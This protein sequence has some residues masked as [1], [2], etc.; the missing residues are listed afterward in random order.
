M[1]A[2]SG[3]ATIIDCDQL[4]D[5]WYFYRIG[6]ITAS[7][8]S[9]LMSKGKTRDSIIYEKASEIVTS[10]KCEYNFSGNADTRRGLESEPKAIAL[11]EDKYNCKVDKIGFAM[12]D[13]FVGCSPDG[14][15]N[16]KKLIEIKS[17]RQK[18]FLRGVVDGI[19]GIKKE[20]MVQIQFNLYVLGLNECDFI[21]YCDSFKEPIHVIN[22][23][24][25]DDFIDDIKKY[26]ETTKSEIA[27]IVHKY[28]AIA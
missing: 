16:D 8:F 12:L 10:K 19:Y 27:S 9:V 23:P 24:R 15:V 6:K 2:Y 21:M 7:N 25:N 18:E 3:T 5:E 20:Y 17:P 13:E 14:I 1:S 26:I 4:S 28:K 11:Y 22:V